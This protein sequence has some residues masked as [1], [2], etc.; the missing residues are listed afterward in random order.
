MKVL[1]TMLITL[2]L[3]LAMAGCSL[4]KIEGQLSKDVKA[5]VITNKKA[6]AKVMVTKDYLEISTGKEE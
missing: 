5:K 1:A 2:G 6:D 3:A 4:T